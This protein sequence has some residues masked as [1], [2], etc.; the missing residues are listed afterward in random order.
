M[1]QYKT[2]EFLPPLPVPD[3]EVAEILAE[4]CP[5]TGRLRRRQI[6]GLPPMPIITL[7]QCKPR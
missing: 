4:L 5:F 7:D 6:L 1:K 2:K 3:H